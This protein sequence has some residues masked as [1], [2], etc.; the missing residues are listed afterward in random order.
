MAKRILVVDDDPA[1]ADVVVFMLTEHGYDVNS[2]GDAQQVLLLK[3][4]LP[5]LML[6]DV[7]LSGNDGRDVCRSL[8]KRTDTKQIP[9]IMFSASREIK[10]T[11]IEAGA[12]DFI[13]KPFEMDELIQ[14]IEEHI[15]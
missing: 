4:N 5:D 10:D 15:N 1:I 8:K 6:L 11:T 2:L 13:E 12:S 7:W 3:D 14:K 9:I